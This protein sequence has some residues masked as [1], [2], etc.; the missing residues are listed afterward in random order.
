MK[1]VL[2][3]FTALTLTFGAARANSAFS[4]E[5]AVVSVPA[6]PAYITADARTA[7]PVSG[8]TSNFAQLDTHARMVPISSGL[9][10]TLIALFVLAMRI[11]GINH[12]RALA[13]QERHSY[14]GKAKMFH[15]LHQQDSSR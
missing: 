7:A 5:L 3:A 13:E 8:T 14:H 2:L 9:V 4:E 1:L 6:V 12:A 15:S 10:L 11:M